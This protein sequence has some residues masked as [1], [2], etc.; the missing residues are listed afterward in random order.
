[1][2]PVAVAQ[3]GRQRLTCR[4]RGGIAVGAGDVD[5]ADAVH[6]PRQPGEHGVVDPADGL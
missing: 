4:H 2:R 1:M 3:L 6:E 5:D